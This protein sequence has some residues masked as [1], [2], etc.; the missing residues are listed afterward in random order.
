MSS[1]S[2][3]LGIISLLVASASWFP[4]N[5]VFE[6]SGVEAERYSP[7][8][9]PA[10]TSTV[11]HKVSCACDCGERLTLRVAIGLGF[12]VV[13]VTTLLNTVVHCCLRPQRVSS[14]LGKGKKGHVLSIRDGI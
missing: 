2:L 12:I 14:G 7:A 1:S 9:A 8:P 11:E 4:W 10:G 6:V 3:S 13:V 5:R